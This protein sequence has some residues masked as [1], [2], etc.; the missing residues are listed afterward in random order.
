MKLT[1]LLPL[2]S[3]L[4]TTTTALVFPPPTNST[5]TSSS[6]SSTPTTPPGSMA[7]GGSLGDLC[8]DLCYCSGTSVTCHADPTSRCVQMCRC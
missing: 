7:C 6:A 2:L 1:H 5:T 8:N 4:T 3:T